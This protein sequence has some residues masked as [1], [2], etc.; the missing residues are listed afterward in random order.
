MLE[1]T[2]ASGAALADELRNVVSQAE[3]LLRAMGDDGD[4]A[5]AALRERVHAS[6][7]TARLRLEDLESEAGRMTQQAAEAAGAYVR[8]N[9]WTA[10]AIGAGLGLLLGG[11]LIGRRRQGPP[12]VQ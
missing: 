4:A 12:T 5:M 11:L 6:L 8:E 3:E 9:P 2:T 7:D 1:N 10:V